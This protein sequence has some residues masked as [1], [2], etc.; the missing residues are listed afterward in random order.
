MV[1]AE[2][3]Y[4]QL[5]A[6]PKCHS[7]LKEFLT[8]ELL[9]ALKGI[10]TDKGGTLED[11]MLSGRV[12]YCCIISY[13]AVAESCTRDSTYLFYLFTYVYISTFKVGL[14]KSRS[15]ETIFGKIGIPEL[16]KSRD[17]DCGIET[18]S[19][20]LPDQSLSGSRTFEKSGLRPRRGTFT[21]SIPIPNFWI[22]GFRDCQFSGSVGIG[23]PFGIS[24]SRP[25]STQYIQSK[26]MNE[27]MR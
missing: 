23:I 10:K 20:P 5:Q 16:L 24:R 22:S 15:P 4:K 7:L 2:D 25:G 1:N 8:K 27:W 9:I 13:R 14:H 12:L 19:G 11:L 18:S 6:N 17:R 21:R 3:G 26:A